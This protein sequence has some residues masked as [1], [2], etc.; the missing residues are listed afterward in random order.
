M[1]MQSININLDT[2]NKIKEPKKRVPVNEYDFTTSI[3]VKEALNDIY[4]GLDTLKYLLKIYPFQKTEPNVVASLL[5]AEDLNDNFMIKHIKNAFM[6]LRN[7]FLRIINS[8]KAFFTYVLKKEAFYRRAITKFTQEYAK[9]SIAITDDNAPIVSL[10][11]AEVFG[12][13]LEILNNL[14]T[15]LLAVYEA[16]TEEALL[17]NISAVQSL[18]YDIVDSKI[19]DTK[20]VKLPPRIDKKLTDSDPSWG[21]SIVQLKDMSYRLLLILN[22]VEKLIKIKVKIDKDSKNTIAT[23]D[24]Y[25]FIGN[26]NKATNLQEELNKSALVT[27]FLY[28]GVVIFQQNVEYLSTQVIDAWQAISALAQPTSETFS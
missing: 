22:R 18:G 16:G 26:T 12:N 2:L 28:N 14:N 11:P 9:N 10:I 17:S 23:I 6:L 15:E 3:A 4:N 7:F 19:N 21:W 1:K 8:S 25:N 5:G 24:R 20:T 13:R 27:G